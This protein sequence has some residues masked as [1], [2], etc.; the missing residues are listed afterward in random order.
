MPDSESRIRPDV[1]PARLAP[2][3]KREFVE[4]LGQ[5]NV[6]DDPAIIAGYSW[7]TGVPSLQ[8][9]NAIRPVAVVLPSST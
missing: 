6:S 4:I 8:Q 2:S 3:V 1:S 5:R 7:A 9:L